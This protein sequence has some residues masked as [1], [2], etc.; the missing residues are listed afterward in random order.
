MLSSLLLQKTAQVDSELDALFRS[1]IR[2]D[3]PASDV[4]PITAKKRKLG[5]LQEVASKR[6]KSRKLESKEADGDSEDDPST[7][8]HES[9][10]DKSKTR[11]PKQKYVPSDETPAQKDQRT[12]FVGNL[13]L[14]VAQKRVLEI[15]FFP[16]S[17]LISCSPYKNSFN[18]IFC[19]SSP[20]PR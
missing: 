3:E 2:T 10:V 20:L 6:T 4:T 12:I 11:G 1:K 16:Y 15:L 13:S 14:Q 8:V 7:L 5:A 17:T 9:L 19:P 18:G